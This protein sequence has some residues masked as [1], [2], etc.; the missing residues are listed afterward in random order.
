MISLKEHILSKSFI[1]YAQI[2]WN[3][4]CSLTHMLF[5]V[6]RQNLKRWCYPSDRRR[7][8]SVC[9]CC[10]NT[11]SLL[12]FFFFPPFFVADDNNKSVTAVFLWVCSWIMW[13]TRCVIPTCEFPRS[14]YQ[15]LFMTVLTCFWL[16]M[17][18]RV[19]RFSPS[20]Y[21][22]PST[23]LWPLLFFKSLAVILKDLFI[24]LSPIFLVTDHSS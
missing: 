17:L 14:D 4:Y 16:S 18:K 1:F 22:M 10:T 8:V 12:L 15:S 20:V 3:D 21:F 6:L 11:A 13:V 23:M 9:V 19:S 24:P 5:W 7:Q 2:N